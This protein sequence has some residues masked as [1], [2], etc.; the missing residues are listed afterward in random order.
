[1]KKRC[2]CIDYYLVWVI[3]IAIFVLHIGTEPLYAQSAAKKKYNVLFI[4][5][6]DL[7]TDIGCYGHPLVKTPNIDALAKRGIRFSRA[8]CQFPL[9]NPSRSSLLTGLNPDVTRV[10]NNTTFIRENI[11]D[12]VTIP[13]LFKNNG[14]YSARVGKVFHY[15]VPGDIGTNGMDDSISWVQRINPKGRDKA[16]E[17]KITNLIPGRALGST[18]AYLTAEGNDEEQ[19]DGKVAT[20]AIKLMQQNKNEPFF[21]TVGFF[22]P[23][24]PYVA[25]E[26]YFDKYPLDKIVLPQEPANDLEDIPEA[27][28]FTKPANWGLSATK[29]KEAIRAYFASI[30]FMDAQVGRVLD[31]LDKLKLG[32]KTIIVF[33]SDHGYNLGEHGQWMKQSLFEKAARVPLLIS[34]PGGLKGKVSGRTVELV[35]LYPTLAELCN[36]P[37]TQKLSGKSLK[38]LLLNPDAKWDRPAYTQLVRGKFSGRSI[39]TERW[40]YTE[41]DGGKAGMELY[42]EVND[43]GEINNLAK[44]PMFAATV[45]ELS[46]LLAKR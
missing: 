44:K 15:G 13:Q 30:S 17:N 11:P 5:V 8:Y 45:K 22:R 19:T 12:V 10:F 39:R 46:E 43:P 38:P 41:W 36:L 25:P 18:L 31:A 26:K 14:Y 16:E 3:M 7:N 32:D 4:A 37:V 9:C 20:E 29:R 42:D 40:R 34:V 27:A 35:D 28:F 23:H 6:D 21:L 1:M 2:E 24:S 33:W